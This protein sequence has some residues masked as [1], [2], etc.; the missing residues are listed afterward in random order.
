[1]GEKQLLKLIAKNLRGVTRETRALK[2]IV[3]ELADAIGTRDCSKDEQLEAMI[4]TKLHE[5]S[6][7]N[8]K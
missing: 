6:T 8:M 5:A 2:R 1:M 4:E 3:G 7:E